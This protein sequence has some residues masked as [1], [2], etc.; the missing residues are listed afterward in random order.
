MR[1]A[2]ALVLCGLC[3]DADAL[4]RLFFSPAQRT[5]LEAE[6]TRASV[7][8]SERLSGVVVRGPGKATVWLD[9]KPVYQAQ[10]AEAFVVGRDDPSRVIWRRAQGLRVGEPRR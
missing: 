7:P 8:S 9:G 1:H 5:R 2:L 3:A 6:R 4:G 10:A